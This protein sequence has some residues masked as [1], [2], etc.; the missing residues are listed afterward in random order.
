[1]RVVG[2]SLAL[3][4]VLS[5]APAYAQTAPAGAGQQQPPAAAAPQPPRPYPEG[6]IKVAVIDIQRIA[7]DSAEGKASTSKVAALNTQ[8][9]NELNDLNK[10]LQADQEKLRTQ[11]AMLSEAARSD[12]ERAIDRQ[13]KEIQRA[14]QDAQEEVQELQIDLQNSFQQKLLPVIQQVVQEKGVHLLFSTADSGIVWAD[15]GLDLTADVLNRFDA[16]TS[17]SGAGTPAAAPA[18]PQE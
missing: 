8:K 14:Q 9:V 5:A 18:K 2:V 17:T 13:Q 6:P 10:K 11:G 3:A 16:A 4:L 15:G 1:M 12:L 7:R